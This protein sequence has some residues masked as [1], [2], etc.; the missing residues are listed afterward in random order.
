MLSATEIYLKQHGICEQGLYFA[1]FSASCLQCWVAHSMKGISH[2]C[3]WLC[4]SPR[5]CHAARTLRQSPAQHKPK[6]R[7]VASLSL[8]WHTYHKLSS[9]AVLSHSLDR[10]LLPLWLPCVIL[11][12]SKWNYP[13]DTL[14]FKSN[15]TSFPLKTEHFVF[16]A[17]NDCGGIVVWG[18]FLS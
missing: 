16:H 3:F 18:K 8:H 7:C 12:I 5:L 11:W 14:H 9:I 2:T 1:R 10:Q 13:S 15:T 6:S 17:G 4:H